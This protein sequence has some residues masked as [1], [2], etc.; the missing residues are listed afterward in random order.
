VDDG[1][2]EHGVG[3]APVARHP[4]EQRERVARAAESAERAR[5]DAEGEGGGRHAV[6]E[7]PAVQEQRVGVAVGPGQRG[8][9]GVVRAEGRG[10]GEAAG[11][12][13]EQVERAAR[14]QGAE[15]RQQERLAE[16]R[17]AGGAREGVEER[18]R[19]VRVPGGPDRSEDGA[20]RERGERERR[21]GGGVPVEEEQGCGWGER[22]R[23]EARQ[24]PRGERV[25]GQRGAQAGQ[26]E[27]RQQLRP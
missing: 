12:L 5:G 10:H 9:H 1:L 7:H 16:R 20:E 13:V 24:A 18:E 22:E 15:Q 3:H 4:A 8:E 11:H 23:E 26:V 27:R 19:A 21:V 25:G 2:V 17:Q 14:G 6:P